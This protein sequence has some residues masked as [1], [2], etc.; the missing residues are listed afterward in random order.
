[1]SVVDEIKERLDIVEV[2]SSYTP[3][4]KSG[5]NYKA[6]CPFHSEKTPSFV[7]FPESQHWHCFGACAEGGD[8]FSFVMKHEGWDFRTALEELARRAGV[9]LRPRTPAQVKEEEEADRLR[10]LLTTAARYYNH[11]LQHASEAK[12]A[13]AYI[14]RRSLD[15]ETVERFRLGYSLPGWNRSRDY[16]TEQ[17]YTIEELVKAGLLVRKETGST[18][19]RFRERLMIP[20]RDAQ[21]RVIGFGARTLDPEGVPKYLNSPQTPLFDKSR[22]LFGLDLARKTIRR[23]DQVVIVEGY[24][25]VMQAQQAGFANVVAQMGT[26]LTE[27]QL[28]QL[29][30]YTKRLVLALDP[31]AAGVQATLRGVEVA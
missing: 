19:D 18:Y 23:K 30:R 26:A 2:I 28:R 15:D 9:E 27:P 24:M 21:G 8:L 22:T 31:D 20:I 11:L 12:A 14:A 29:Q 3:L 1:M 5:R 16:L 25:D 17:G 6:L 4:K 7:V 10:E 13:R